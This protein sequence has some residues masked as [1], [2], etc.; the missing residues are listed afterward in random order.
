MGSIS[1]KS[2]RRRIGMF[3]SERKG[4]VITENDSCLRITDLRLKGRNAAFSIEAY[5]EDACP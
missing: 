4:G 3:D 5:A 2:I 1:I